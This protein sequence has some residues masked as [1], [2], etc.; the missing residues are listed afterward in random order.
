MKIGISIPESLHSPNQLFEW[1]RRVDQGPFS[2]LSIL[3]RVVY[4]NYEPLM[5]LATAAALSTRVRL[6]TEV[7]L[8]PL[9]NTT[10]LAKETATLDVLS[11][12]RLT[13]GLGVGVR[14]DDFIA[15]GAAYQGRGKH[16][17]EQIS[18]MRHIWSGQAWNDTVGP[19]GP[20]PVQTNGPEIILGGFVPRALQRA[21]RYADGFITALNNHEQIGNTF[22]S[23]EQSWKEAN[24]SG[25]PRLIAQIDIALET[26]HAGQGRKN[27]TDYYKTLPPYDTDKAATLLTT[28]QQLRETIRVVE[29][30]GADEVIFFTWSSEIEQIDRI[31]GLID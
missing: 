4:S 11:K 27:V 26:H 10:L 12:G 30:L 5:T 9:R 13:L 6:M 8:C 14:E 22:R 28:E 19:I 15:T 21:A 16:I 7:L 24:R 2:T 17:E 1:V 23:V 3:D 31:A 25:K 20:A 29:Q 18:Q